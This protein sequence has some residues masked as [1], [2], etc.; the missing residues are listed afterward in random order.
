VIQFRPEAARELS[1]DVRYDDEK[2]P[3]RGQRLQHE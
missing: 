1:A 2:Y 3:G